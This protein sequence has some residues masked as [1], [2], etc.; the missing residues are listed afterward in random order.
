MFDRSK[1]QKEI[2]ELKE[3][4]QLLKHNRDLEVERLKKDREYQ[5]RELKQLIAIKEK[6]MECEKEVWEATKL[7]EYEKES[8]KIRAEYYLKME[9]FLKLSTQDIKDVLSSVLARLPDI[10]AKLKGSV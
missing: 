7:K 6:K 9:E 10:S 5:D 8:S 3:E 4:I 2:L 1:L